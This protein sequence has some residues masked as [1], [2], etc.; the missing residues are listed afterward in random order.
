MAVLGYKIANRRARAKRQSSLLKSVAR[1]RVAEP[2]LG[3]SLD[4]FTRSRVY[5]C[6]QSIDDRLET[7]EELQ[8][9]GYSELAANV[10]YWMFRDPQVYKERLFEYPPD[11]AS[12]II[13]L[14]AERVQ[15]YDDLFANLDRHLENLERFAEAC[16]ERGY[17]N[18][19]LA[20]RLSNYAHM[21]KIGADW[22]L[23]SP[24]ED[25]VSIYE[26][27]TPSA[28][29]PVA[30]ARQEVIEWTRDHNLGVPAEAGPKGHFY[31]GIAN[32]R[33]LLV[34]FN[35]NNGFLA[36]VP[37]SLFG[38]VA[39]R[40][41]ADDDA[42]GPNC[43]HVPLDDLPCMRNLLYADY[44]TGTPRELLDKERLARFEIGGRF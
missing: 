28:M 21:F 43:T 25:L 33:F 4:G 19:S 16:F 44:R 7:P 42:L 31:D 1:D 9:Q 15:T 18:P 2:L 40:R 20:L 10:V 6:A 38:D 11:L 5:N 3:A 36:I 13:N 24:S 29:Q 41:D 12:A 23:Q 35:K 14:S 30:L 22:E 26:T 32:G 8:Q 37:D 27:E 17:T 34:G 39:S